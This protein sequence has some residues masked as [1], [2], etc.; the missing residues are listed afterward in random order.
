MFTLPAGA[1]SSIQC[2]EHV[3]KAEEVP[4][5]KTGPERE[6][7]GEEGLLELMD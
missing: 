2:L 7:L 4:E 3:P 6:K 1:N 5:L